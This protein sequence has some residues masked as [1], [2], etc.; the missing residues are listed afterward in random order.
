MGAL[1]GQV[2]RMVEAL[3]KKSDSQIT[4]SASVLTKIVTAA[5][6]ANG[7]WQ[8]PLSNEKFEAMKQVNTEICSARRVESHRLYKPELQAT[9]VVCSLILVLL[10]LQSEHAAGA[11]LISS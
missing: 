11:A 6:D 8:L 3:V 5:A 4:D 2:M 7:E 9:N 1:A 10:R